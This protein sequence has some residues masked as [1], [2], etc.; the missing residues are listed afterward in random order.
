[1]SMPP[2]TDEHLLLYACG[3]LEAARQA[4]VEAA[5]SRDPVKAAQVVALQS[6][7]EDATRGAGAD[8]MIAPDF[9]ARLKQRLLAQGR[10]AEAIPIDAE[11][12]A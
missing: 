12:A 10:S 8:A 4:E 6:A 3:E 2:V 11:G 9:N 5:L 1:M 7:Y